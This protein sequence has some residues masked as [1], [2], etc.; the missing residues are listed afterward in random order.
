MSHS[1][2]NRFRSTRI[3]GARAL[4]AAALVLL[5]ACAE[6]SEDQVGGG[7][8]ASG[9]G[10]EAT[11]SQG[12]G[13]VGGAF[14]TSSS[15]GGDPGVSEVFGHS[16]TTLYKLNPD[17]KD[18]GLVGNFVGCQGVQDIALD[19][20]SNLF[21]TT[22]TALWQVDRVTAQCT[23]IANGSYPN[24]L[25]FVPEG[26]L[27]PSVEALVGFVD[28]QY[29]RIDPETGSIQNIGAPW[30]NGFVSSGDVVS[31]KDGPTF[32]TIKDAPG[33]G[34][35]CAD[36][37][38]AIDP[39]TGIIQTSYPNLGY[40]RVFGTAFWAGSV[41]GFTSQGDLF[42]VIIDGGALTTVPIET[43]PG[44]SF[45]GAGST[46]SAPPVPR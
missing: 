37:L 15:G 41:Y 7:G 42:E 35:T 3:S 16:A 38:V 13:G 21:A 23:L 2:A 19:K 4:G 26:T 33:G 36:C 40:D 25:S 28:D 29:V 39:A 31:V 44:L 10:G 34:A 1:V 11:A 20:S 45:W 8:A 18:V 27:D 14:G 24:S 43:P 30:S 5:G 32:L 17:T 6:G 46:T 9:A 22:T 12:G